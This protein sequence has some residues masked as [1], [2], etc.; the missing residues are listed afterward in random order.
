MQPFQSE[1]LHQ[2]RVGLLLWVF[3]ARSFV[4]QG[5]SA[6]CLAGYGSWP[7]AVPAGEVAMESS[8]E[9][10]Q[11]AE[12]Y[13]RMALSITDAQ[14]TEALNELAA[15]FDALAAT[16]EAAAGPLGVEDQASGNPSDPACGLVSPGNSGR[17]GDPG[18]AECARR[19]RRSAPPSRRQIRL[20]KPL[21]RPGW[22]AFPPANFFVVP[23]KATGGWC[24]LHSR[25][26]KHRPGSLTV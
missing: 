4:R 11:R 25:F 7:E 22:P 21:R 3:S 16:L 13:R 20:S 1:G 6:G 23:A 12:R 24:A 5:C 9:L 26:C 10:R 15:E 17:P 8:D 18:F 2:L 14:A 19:P